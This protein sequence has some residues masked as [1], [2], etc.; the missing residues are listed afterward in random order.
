M[1][2]VVGITPCMKPW[3]RLNVQ[4]RDGSGSLTLRFTGR[5]QIAGMAVGRGL[6]VD[7][8]P[9][10]VRGELIFLNPV[11]SFVTCRDS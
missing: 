7:G 6:V 9:A 2:R 1:G 10:L 4:L 11:Y 3:G 5:R 8:T